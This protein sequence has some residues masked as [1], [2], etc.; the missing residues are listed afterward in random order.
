MSQD[1]VAEAL[2]LLH[3]AQLEQNAQSP[4]MSAFRR[5]CGAMC[6][7]IAI[8]FLTVNTVMLGRFGYRM[9]HDEIESWMQAVIA[10]SIPWVLALLPF[11]LMMTWIPA[12]MIMDRRGRMR[13][14]RGRP[15]FATLAAAV[16]YIVFVA[17]NFVG[18]IGV[19]AVARQSV[20]GKA[21]QADGEGKRLEDS[22]ARL[23]KQMDAITK[24]RPQ[25]ELASLISRHQQHRF[26]KDLN[27]CDKGSDLIRSRSHRDYCVAYDSLV[28]EQSRAKRGDELT[29]QIANLDAL[30]SNPQRTELIAND[31]QAS[32][33]AKNF[34]MDED[35]VRLMMPLMW[36]VLLELG[37]ML[38]A[39]FA[40]KLFRVSH[41]SLIDMPE[42]AQPIHS[43]RQLEAPGSAYGGR[44]GSRGQPLDV[45][46]I[47][48]QAH[49]VATPSE[50]PHRQRAVF[51]EFWGHRVRRSESAQTPESVIYTHY[52]G[53]C[54]EH[55][56]VPYTIETFQRMSA[57]HIRNRV[58]EMAGVRRYIGLV[59][60]DR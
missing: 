23:V 51:D 36:P 22:R 3:Q 49:T 4:Q 13:R 6:A 15:S 52:R 43:L 31:A 34:G 8:A 33:I 37:S 25:D 53:M 58:I 29:A 40:L 2:R 60:T 17:T 44:S 39:Y 26:W 46:P 59:P 10:G 54:A 48:L 56:V 38:L 47:P 41:H 30:L 14:R 5:V 50:D 42:G 32:V 24:Y 9:G 20:H 27:G 16:L 21:Q 18:G 55:L 35:R 57:E 11:I 28:A 19:M 1:A 7:V 12:R 45:E